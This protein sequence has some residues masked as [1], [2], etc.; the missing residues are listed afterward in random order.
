MR[1]RPDTRPAFLADA[2]LLG[3]ARW[4]RV[5][6][7]DTSAHPDRDDPELVTLADR[8][9]RCLLTRDRRLVEELR[10]ARPQLI[11]SDAPLQQLAEVADHH[12]LIRAPGL[13]QRCLQCNIRVRPATLLE[14]YRHVPADVRAHARSIR[15]CPGCGHLY[16]PGSHTEHM[17]RALARVLPAGFQG[18]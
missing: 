5:L 11:E 16:W 7:F 17:R 1:R 13:F 12:R 18:L 3:L 9:G 8:E 15:R 6:G 2:M 4:L 14:R 10:P